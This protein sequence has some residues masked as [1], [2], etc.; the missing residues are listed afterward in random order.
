MLLWHRVEPLGAIEKPFS[1]EAPMILCGIIFVP[2]NTCRTILHKTVLMKWST[3]L[4][5]YNRKVLC[6][7]TLRW[8]H[9]EPLPDL[10]CVPTFLTGGNSGRRT[11]I[12]QLCTS[13]LLFETCQTSIPLSSARQR[14]CSHSRTRK[15]TLP[16]CNAVDSMPAIF[17]ITGVFQSPEV[18]EYFPVQPHKT[19]LLF[20]FPGPF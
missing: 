17:I 3:L 15:N 5:C 18:L 12:S 14:A 13:P 7:T 19:L 6:P 9:E 2:K 11:A 8:F 20:L 16:R 1:L 4:W 10:L